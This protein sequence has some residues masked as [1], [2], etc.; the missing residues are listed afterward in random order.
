MTKISLKK[1]IINSLSNLSSDK[2]DNL[3]GSNKLVFVTAAGIISGYPCE[4]NSK[5]NPSTFQGLMSMFAGISLDG[6][7]ENIQSLEDINENDGFILLKDVTINNGPSTFSTPS[8][9][10]F[11]D[12][13]IAV[14]IGNPEIS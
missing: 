4:I 11:F 1:H 10:L 3:I 2:P 8:F 9:F 13:V 7:E 5:S 12:Q 6:Y 14:A